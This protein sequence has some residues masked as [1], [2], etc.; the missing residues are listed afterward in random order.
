MSGCSRNT[1]RTRSTSSSA[2]A[3]CAIVQTSAAATSKLHLPM[4]PPIAAATAY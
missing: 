4:L 3:G 2:L 1:L